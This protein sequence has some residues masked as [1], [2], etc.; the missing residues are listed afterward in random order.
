MEETPSTPTGGGMPGPASDASKL[1]AGFGYIF[2]V[3]ALVALLIEPY[4]DE[5]FVRIHALQAIVLGI[6]MWLSWI[7]FLGWIAGIVALVF[8][9][10]ALIKAFQ[11][12]YYEVP[13]VYNLVQRWF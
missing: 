7:P 3:V 6:V 2:W 4:K 5:P 9:I 12:Q 1:L 11:G 10:I 13:L 8:A